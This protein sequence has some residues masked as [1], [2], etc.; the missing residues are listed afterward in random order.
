MNEWQN[1]ICPICFKRYK[2][3]ETTHLLSHIAEKLNIFPCTVN[4]NNIIII[5]HFDNSSII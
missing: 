2:H 1:V 3:K 4:I 5:F